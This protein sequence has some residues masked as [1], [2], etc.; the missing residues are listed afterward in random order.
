MSGRT[1]P[2]CG[3]AIPRG[4]LLCKG[5]WF[6]VPRKLRDEVNRS[7]RAFLVAEGQARMT[8]LSNYRLAA[9][10][11]TAIAKGALP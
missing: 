6:A 1:C 2:A 9:D 4:K 3:T 7:W 5:C 8:A 10:A 11:A